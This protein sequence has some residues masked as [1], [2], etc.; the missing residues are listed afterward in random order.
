M[1][2]QLEVNKRLY[3]DEKTLQKT[4]GFARLQ[5]ALAALVDVVLAHA[6]REVASH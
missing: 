6:S 3:M 2:L 5:K 1:S 4:A